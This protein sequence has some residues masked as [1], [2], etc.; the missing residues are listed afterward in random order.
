MSP[1]MPLQ[2]QIQA[3]FPQRM[4][5][6]RR[7]LKIISCP[8]CREIHRGLTTFRAPHEPERE[9]NSKAKPPS[10]LK[11]LGDSA[12]SS[13]GLILVTKSMAIFK[14]RTHYDE[15]FTA[16]ALLLPTTD[17]FS[18]SL[19]FANGLEDIDNRLLR[20][21]SAIPPPAIEKIP[22]RPDAKRYVFCREACFDIEK[23]T[24]A[25]ID[26]NGPSRS[27]ISSARLSTESLK[28]LTAVKLEKRRFRSFFCAQF[29]V[30]QVLSC[31]HATTKDPKALKRPIADFGRCAIRT[32]GLAQGKS[33]PPAFPLIARHTM[34]SF[35]EILNRHAKKASP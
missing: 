16:K 24:R 34:A 26:E 4:I 23:N 29:K 7:L 33:S 21:G 6:G 30:G 18:H 9:S 28:F 20:I 17:W 25:P 22:V 31:K 19:F 5:I 15:T 11:G 1:L 10:Q 13:A 8:I 12:H 32:H 35:A 14:R 2:R 3:L 27:S